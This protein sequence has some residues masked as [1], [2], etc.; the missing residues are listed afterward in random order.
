MTTSA[1]AP[2][3]NANVLR[4]RFNWHE[5]LTKDPE[6]A[7]RFYTAVVGWGTQD[8]PA[9][10]PPYTMWLAGETPVGGIMKLPDDAIAQGAPSNWLTYIETPDVDETVA[11][12][13]G[14]G[15]RTFVAPSD[16]PNVGR[17]AVLADPQGA[18]F[19]LYMPNGSRA[20]S[21][22]PAIG[23]FSWHELMTSDQNA[24]FQFYHELFGWSKTS[25]MDMGDQG[26]Y[27]MFGVTSEVPLGGIY[28]IDEDMSAP[29][30]WLP[31]V[32][33]DYAD[34]AVDRVKDAGGTLKN[35]P[36]EVP[37]G[38]RIAICADPQGCVF[39]VHSRG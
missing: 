18:M 35:G 36:M 25:A 19:A 1:Q 20:D 39:A 26:V 11:Q 28:N 33:V 21:G 5:L 13:T 27:Q 7:K 37:G 23:E 9:S 31:Y 17:F 34:A 12:A 4:G 3:R 6:S 15:A 32:R 24:A 8:F 22:E 10:N 29:P 16:I 30:N 14:L 38:D 2:M